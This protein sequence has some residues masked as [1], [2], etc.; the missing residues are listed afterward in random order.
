MR[1][2][3]GLIYETSLL[4]PI[5]GIRFRGLSI[6]EVCK[7]LPKARQEPLPEA[8]FFLLLTGRVP[9]QEETD[10]V[11]TEW[12]ARARPVDERIRRMIR[13]NAMVLH[14]M[15]LFSMSVLAMQEKSLFAR[16]YASGKLSKAEMWQP[17]LEDACNLIAMLP[18]IAA[19]IY[20]YACRGECPPSILDPLHSS[21]NLIRLDWSARLGEMMLAGTD[22][23]IGSKS[24][25]FA[26]LLRLYLTIHADHEGGNV[27]A[28]ATKLVASSLADPYLAFSAGLNGLAGPLHGLANQE[29]LRWMF[30][31]MEQIGTKPSPERI[32]EYLWEQLKVG[33]VIPGFG[34][35][36]LRRTDP[37]YLVQREFALRH[38]PSEDPLF[39]LCSQ[40]YDIVPKVLEEHGKTKNPFPNVD[41][42][43]GVLLQY[44]GIR[45]Q[46]FY[47]VL[48]GVSRAIGVLTSLVWDRALGAPL[49]RPKSWTSDAIEG[50]LSPQPKRPLKTRKNSEIDQKK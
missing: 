9:T 24:E 6:P 34:H 39:S 46:N 4:D 10:L 38:L 42:H 27:S 13:E 31:L 48:F 12:Q 26:D 45:E 32:T 1:D 23:N 21:S 11:I 3:N 15:T 43:S 19:L 18:E 7:A 40:L 8:L 44:Y 14:P 30:T 2:I 25:E 22:S 49:E 16:E 50:M 29:V 37:R 35:A 33:K 20:R 41:A 5:E 36:V 47:T 28:H 17:A